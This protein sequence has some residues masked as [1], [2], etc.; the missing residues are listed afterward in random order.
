[1]PHL[2]DLNFP[3]VAQATVTLLIGADAPEL[4]LIRNNCKGLR[5]QPIAVETPLGWSLLGPSLSPSSRF[6]CNV[7]LCLT[8][9]DK[10]LHKQ[11]ERL[12]TTDFLPENAS[13]GKPSSREDRLTYDLLKSSVKQVSI[14]TYMEA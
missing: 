9:R 11:I 10:E 13:L 12:W 4:F 5:G 14:T 7:N 6:N 1:M 3:K 2:K 8:T